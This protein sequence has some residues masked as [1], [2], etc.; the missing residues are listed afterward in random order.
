MN[1]TMKKIFTKAFNKDENYK[2]ILNIIN[3]NNLNRREIIKN[4][5][6]QYT[7]GAVATA[8]ALTL[9]YLIGK[10]IFENKSLKLDLN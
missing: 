7:I 6:P 5:L 2:E 1:K 10:K 9:T 8:G 3:M 4:K